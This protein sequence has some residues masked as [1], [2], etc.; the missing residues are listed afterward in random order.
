MTEKS[1]KGK[2][3]QLKVIINTLQLEFCLRTKI[4]SIG[5]QSMKQ[6]CEEFVNE[7][8]K[9]LN[10]VMRDV[11]TLV[12]VLKS[13]IGDLEKEAGLLKRESR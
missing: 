8:N 10:N 4:N 2:L 3:V 9:K 12:D 11:T 5:M 13:N 6:T 7:L 1:R